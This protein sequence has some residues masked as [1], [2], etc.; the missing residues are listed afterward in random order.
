MDV[1]SDADTAHALS[2]PACASLAARV[3]WAALEDVARE[4][5]D[6][7]LLLE[8]PPKVA[9]EEE[10]EHELRVNVPHMIEPGED[11]VLDSNEGGE[12]PGYEDEA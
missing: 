1:A 6:G 10:Q 9:E 5:L 2:E 8:E 3:L 11:E 7:N 4:L 12:W